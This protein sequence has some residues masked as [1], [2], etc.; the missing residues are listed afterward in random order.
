MGYTFRDLNLLQQALT[1]TSYVADHPGEAKHNERLEFLGDAALKLTVTEM[2]LERFPMEGEGFLTKVRAYLVSDKH[3]S[4]LAIKLS[5]KNLIRLGRSITLN[6]SRVASAGLVA[7]TLEAILGAVFQ[8]GGHRLSDALIRRLVSPSLDALEDGTLEG[9]RDAHGVLFQDYKTALQERMMK[10]YKR[11]PRYLDIAQ[12]GDPTK[13]SFTVA[14]LLLDVELARGKGNSKKE[15]GQQAAK[16]ALARLTAGEPELLEALEQ[17]C[18]EATAAANTASTGRSG[19]VSG[20]K[21]VTAESHAQGV[22]RAETSGTAESVSTAAAELAAAEA[23]IAALFRNIG[24]N[25][26]AGAD[27][28]S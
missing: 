9:F 25:P 11:H 16:E 23:R 5:L 6:Q 15:A 27:A 18:N 21:G 8:D 13:P 2:L 28:E 19:D 3:L 10:V 7:N 17:A 24:V 12:E 1:H 22:K 14:T 26:D 20:R 4:E